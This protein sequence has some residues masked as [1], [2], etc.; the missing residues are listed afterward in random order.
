MFDLATSDVGRSNRIHSEDEILVIQN[1]M[2]D[3]QQPLDLELVARCKV[4]L[5]PHRKLP[6]DILRCIFA[7]H[8]QESI[9]L[10]F[11]IKR[12]MLRTAVV[13]TH[14][15]SL[16]RC[17]AL[18]S[19]ELWND[20]SL[21]MN[22]LDCTFLPC[23]LELLSRARDLPINLRLTVRFHRC[24]SG[25]HDFN[26]SNAV[27]QLTS[28][29]NIQKLQ[30]TIQSSSRLEISPGDVFAIG[31][32]DHVRVL[33]VWLFEAHLYP[34]FSQ[35]S[36]PNLEAFSCYTDSPKMNLKSS[37]GV[38]W[39]RLRRLHLLGYKQDMTTTLGLLSQCMLIEECSLGMTVSG[40]IVGPKVT[41]HNLRDLQF[42]FLLEQDLDVLDTFFSLLSFPNLQ[43]LVVLEE[44]RTSSYTSQVMSPLARNL[45]FMAP[46]LHDL[47]FREPIDEGKASILQKHMPSL[48]ISRWTSSR[49]NTYQ[50]L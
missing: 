27:Y 11:L 15:C 49:K 23:A 4:A 26:F 24:H 42:G 13:L 38:P 8:A 6:G 30:L 48:H 33:E 36:L 17:I 40:S 28:N 5:A 19:P 9:Y 29:R 2:R 1:A 39:S 25:D 34:I 18:S 22:N 7:F 35:G 45:K 37:A 16:W 14:V 50:P 43:S 41:L 46:Q 31:T 10:P 44:F 47:R 12:D 32:F 20:I 21:R 3:A